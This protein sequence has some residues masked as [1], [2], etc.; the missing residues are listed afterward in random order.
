[1]HHEARVDEGESLEVV[2]VQ[3]HQQQL[4]HGTVTWVFA[5][6]VEVAAV[7]LVR[8]EG[9]LVGGEGKKGGG[10]V[11]KKGGSERRGG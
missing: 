10:R 9:V 2:F 4:V 3:L 1:M 5:A 11:R 8:L 7:V 6:A